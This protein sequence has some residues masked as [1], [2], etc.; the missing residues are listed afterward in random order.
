[1]KVESELMY[2]PRQNTCVQPQRQPRRRQGG[3]T[4]VELLVVIGI[5]ALLIS[6]L[7][8]SLNKA[9]ESANRVK[10]LSNLRQLGMAMQMYAN[11][12]KDQ[13]AIGSTGNNIQN[14]YSMFAVAGKRWQPMG[15]YYFTGLI[16]SPESYYCPSDIDGYYG[17]NT[18]QNPFKPGDLAATSDTRA[19]YGTR[20]VGPNLEVL[21]DTQVQNVAAVTN[22]A[23]IRMIW[24]RTQAGNGNPVTDF[25]AIDQSAPA[26]NWNPFPK[27]SQFKRKAMIS[28]IFPSPDR[29]TMRHRDGLNV[30]Y[31]DGSASWVR[32]DV[33][34]PEIKDI[35]N[36]VNNFNIKYNPN[37]IRA[38]RL[39]DRNHG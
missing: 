5:I 21:D 4:L 6:I 26:N 11:Q 9:R 35:P 13:V 7:L 28:D 33:I 14:N 39:L 31:S 36:G 18:A 22:P 37:M 16:K 8:P 1:V 10:C 17:Y 23:N 19:A 34:W 3:F 38:W 2:H 15:I 20:P 24:W 29:I 32:K 12:N 25:P 27:L 30:Y